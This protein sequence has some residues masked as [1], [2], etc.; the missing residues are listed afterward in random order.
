MIRGGNE[1]IWQEERRWLG[2]IMCNISI[3]LVVVQVVYYMGTN[4]EDVYCHVYDCGFS[5]GVSE[6]SIWGK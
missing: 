5:K 4:G 3:L 1:G 6:L 2:S